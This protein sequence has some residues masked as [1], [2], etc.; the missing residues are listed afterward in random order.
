MTPLIEALAQ[1]AYAYSFSA[2]M[3]GEDWERVKARAEA[4]ATYAGHQV[5]R[6]YRQA[7]HSLKVFEAMK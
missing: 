1:V 4:G 2:S 7:V 6:C 5:E 3:S